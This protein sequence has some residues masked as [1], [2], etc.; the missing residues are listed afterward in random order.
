[1]QNLTEKEKLGLINEKIFLSVLRLIFDEEDYRIKS[2]DFKN[3]KD[4]I[5][6]GVDFRIFERNKSLYD[7]E[8][9][10]WRDFDRPYGI[11]I[12]KTEMLERFKTSCA[13]FKILI[14]SF[15][16]LIPTEGL[17]LLNQHHIHVFEVG[18]LLGKKVFKNK[19][20][21][22]LKSKLTEFLYT[23][24]QQAK[25]RTDFFGVNSGLSVVKLTSYCNTNSVVTDNNH[26]NTKQV[27]NNKQQ[28]D[29]PTQKQLDKL[30]SQDQ[31]TAIE[32]AFRHVKLKLETT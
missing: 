13:T 31:I 25:T 22:E 26:Y 17:K 8:A 7:I 14:I 21:Y 12:V 1:M 24:K 10:N 30:L 27:T 29:T 28:H 5:K 9:K 20:F 16:S 3:Y 6:K 23:I 15:M 4:G 11:D 19:F 32:E 2:N 18:R